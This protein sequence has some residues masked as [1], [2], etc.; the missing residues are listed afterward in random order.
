MQRK[1]IC[2]RIGGWYKE[3]KMEKSPSD[4]KPRLQFIK[5]RV[6]AAKIGFWWRRRIAKIKGGSRMDYFKTKVKS[7]ILI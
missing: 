3:L 7:V 5:K 6:M 1:I 4:P 2:N